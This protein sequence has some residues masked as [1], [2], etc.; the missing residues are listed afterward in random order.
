MA[1]LAGLMEGEQPRRDLLIEHLH[2]IQDRF[3]H[4]SEAHLAAP[5]R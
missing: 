2:R 5:P 3:G 4:I 1:E